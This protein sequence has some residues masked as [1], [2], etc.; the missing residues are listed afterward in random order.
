[1]WS[2]IGSS[3][4]LEQIKEKSRKIPI[5]DS[6]ELRYLEKSVGY[7]KNKEIYVETYLNMYLY[8]SMKVLVSVKNT[9]STFPS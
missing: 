6:I 1:M 8:L 3:C 5:D 2:L 4:L 9:F 7:S